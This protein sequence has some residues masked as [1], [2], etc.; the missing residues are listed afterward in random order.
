MTR[1]NST[2]ATTKT[3]NLAGGQAY[4]Q[5][6]RQEFL[7]ILFTSF[8]KD[9]F[10][11]TAD[12]T[13]S[14]IKSL[15]VNEDK[16][17]VAKAAIY[18][19]TKLGMRSVSHLVASEVAKAVKGATWSRSF[20]QKI[21]NRPDDMTEILACYMSS[22]GKPIP[23]SLKKGFAKVLEGLDDYKLAK[24]RMGGKDVSM[25]DVINM[26]HPRATKSLTK[27]IEGQ[28]KNLDTWE[29]KLS[30]AGQSEGEDTDSAKADAWAS[31][32]KE[33]KLG[34]MALLKNLRNI[35]EQAPECVPMACEQLVNKE[36]IQKSLVFPFRFATAFKQLEQVNAD[37]TRKVLNALSHAT[38]LSMS[39][40]PSFPGKT[41]IVL[42]VS[43][44]MSSVIEKAALFASVL[45]KACDSDLMLFES[46]A[47]YETFMP[48]DTTLFIAERLEQMAHG[49]G[50][51]FHSI[52]ET[53]NRAYDRIVILSDMQGW[54]GNNCPTKTLQAY[55]QRTGA[56]PHVFSFDLAG[57]GSLQFP[58]NNVYCLAGFSDKILGMMKFLEEDKKAIEHEIESIVL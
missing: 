36:A 7:S 46:D 2:S 24:Y 4:K 33:G 1:F 50:T 39:N 21:V 12:D 14:R 41:L 26:V 32:L 19:R 55:K 51:N 30:G 44:S 45:Y 52:F 23:N 17:F 49:G 57:Y 40:V 37:G 13:I 10:Y 54:I 53:A 48:T 29:A 38:D 34:Y 15:I 28:L 11:Q 43:G 9:Q 8:L 56:N 31:L 22:Y 25:V 42:D 27:L 58:E 35:L 20:F 6:S 3:V 5:T 16:K 47:H 18:A